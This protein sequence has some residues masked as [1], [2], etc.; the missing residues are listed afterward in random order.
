PRWTEHRT[1][2]PLEVRCPRENACK[3][4]RETG[5]ISK[6]G[7]YVSRFPGIRACFPGIAFPR[8]G[9][10]TGEHQSPSA[11]EQVSEV[12]D[13]GLRARVASARGMV[14]GLRRGRE[15]RDPSLPSGSVALQ[16]IIFR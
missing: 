6:S 3:R 15:D 10:P 16:L 8:R 4:S 13:T 14:A 7:S 5:R 2:E 9:K 11:G 1:S 12:I